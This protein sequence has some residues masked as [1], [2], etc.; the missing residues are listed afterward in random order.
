MFRIRD[1]PLS[2]RNY[3]NTEYISLFDLYFDYYSP[4]FF[5]KDKYNAY[6]LGHKTPEHFGYVT[7]N[8]RPMQ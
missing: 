7:L 2:L 6:I 3:Q 1:K 8:H 4:M 5:K